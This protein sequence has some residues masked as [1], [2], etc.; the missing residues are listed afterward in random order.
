[1]AGFPAP[2]ARAQVRLPDAAGL[3]AAAE[4]LRA[5]GVVAMPTETV[6][7][8]AGNAFHEPALARIFDV[9]ERPTFDPLIVHVAAMAAPLRLAEL[10]AA[11]LVDAARLPARLA[12]A[13]E[14]L[15]ARFWPGPLTLVL[16]K[17]DDVPDLATSG[18][19][20][21][22]VRMPAHPVAQALLAAAG[23]PLAAPSANRFGRV[24]PTSAEAVLEE[25]GD[26]IPL[27]LDGGRCAV[28]VEST[29]VSVGQDPE[30]PGALVLL[31][32]GAISAAQIE[33]ATGLAVVPPGETGTRD[34]PKASPGLLESHYAPRVPLVLLPSPVAQLAPARAREVA[35]EAGAPPGAVVGL[36]LLSGP[37]EP[38]A[39]AF[40]AATGLEVHARAL[41]AGG[42]LTEVAHA[43][44]AELRAIDRALAHRDEAVLFCEPCPPTPGL[45]HA[46]ADR[47]QRASA[48]RPRG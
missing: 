30:Q 47:L 12:A 17:R 40:T 7:G 32:P 24:S 28:G 14:A 4:I 15:I 45:G 38:A 10:D 5:G 29:V 1:M 37:A 42:D 21:V 36:L 11:R 31:R 18:L 13:A 39:A 23:T 41:S 46:I 34:G 19:P 16:P 9:K 35:R 8:L 44:F 2:Q 20:S 33:A 26:R 25:L 22:A 48:P 27:I 3:A 43:L 6:Y